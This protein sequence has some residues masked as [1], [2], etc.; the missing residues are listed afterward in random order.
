MSSEF[1]EKENKFQ[2][3]NLI[4]YQK[5]LDFIDFVYEFTLKVPNFESFGLASQFQRAANSIA[6]NI[7]E[8]SGGTR[9]E[10]QQFIRFAR[11]SA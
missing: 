6:L 10:F 7:A 2:F 4:V 11:R 8:G 1:G 5:T 3:E 9:L